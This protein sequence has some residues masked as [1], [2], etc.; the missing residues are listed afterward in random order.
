MCVYMN[1][2]LLLNSFSQTPPIGHRSHLVSPDPA[3]IRWCQV[4]VRELRLCK[5][6]NV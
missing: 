5:K 2:T 6:N 3:F 4:T 1:I